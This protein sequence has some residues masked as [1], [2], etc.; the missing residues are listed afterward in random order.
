MA[1]FQ[2]RT[3]SQVTFRRALGKQQFWKTWKLCWRHPS[4][5]CSLNLSFTRNSESDFCAFA[6]VWVQSF[7]SSRCPSSN[8]PFL[9]SALSRNGLESSFSLYE[10]ATSV[11][12]GKES[13]A[14][15]R[16]SPELSCWTD[17]MATWIQWTCMYVCPLEQLQRSSLLALV[18][19]LDR[20][21]L[22]SAGCFDRHCNVSL[23]LRLQI[24]INDTWWKF[25]LFVANIKR[26][27]STRKM[28]P[29]SQG[30]YKDHHFVPDSLPK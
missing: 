30:K 2:S 18:L 9:G 14:T 11:L 1:R 6:A 19:L 27:I 8:R 16:K 7:D 29:C 4:L 22:H 20:V 25:C 26:W 12:D 13:H 5:T 24:L 21:L 15:Q 10:Q 3:I 28:P 23:I 17:L